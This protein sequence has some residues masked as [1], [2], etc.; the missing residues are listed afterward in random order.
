MKKLVGKFGKYNVAIFIIMG[1]GFVVWLLGLP[2]YLFFKIDTDIFGVF[3][4]LIGLV[5]YV[6]GLIVRLIME[7]VR[8]N[9]QV[10]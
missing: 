6:V 8:S 1:I 9:K 10:K 2:L 7:K 3:I 4:F 5:M